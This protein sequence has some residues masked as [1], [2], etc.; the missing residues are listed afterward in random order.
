MKYISSLY[1]IT[2]IEIKNEDI[3]MNN[4]III[5][6]KKSN[7]YIICYQKIYNKSRKIN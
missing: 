3:N 1:S 7:K 5:L 4:E 2:I 6:N